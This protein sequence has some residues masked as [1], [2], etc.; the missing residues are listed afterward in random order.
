MMEASHIHNLHVDYTIG[1]ECGL[2]GTH[3]AEAMVMCCRCFMWFHYGC[4]DF[5]DEGG[6]WFCF[7]C[8]AK[9]ARRQDWPSDHSAARR[10]A[11][12]VIKFIRDTGLKFM[13]D[14]HE[15]SRAVVKAVDK[16][17]RR[18][19]IVQDS[20]NIWI[21][22]GRQ[23]TCTDMLLALHIS[24][25][26]S[27]EG[28]LV[29]LFEYPAYATASVTSIADEMRKSF[30]LYMRIKLGRILKRGLHIAKLSC[31]LTNQDLT[32]HSTVSEFRRAEEVKN[33]VNEFIYSQGIRLSG[34]T[35]DSHELWETLKAP[36]TDF[37]NDGDRQVLLPALEV[38]LAGAHSTVD[39]SKAEE[40]LY[41]T[42]VLAISM[43]DTATAEKSLTINTVEYR[44]VRG[45]QVVPID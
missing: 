23:D 39:L 43:K 13:D 18:R 4:C 35:W 25:S 2:C 31:M 15:L 12:P 19:S 11:L 28:K 6:E 14:Q 34:R 45:L 30:T 27:E 17:N 22:G 29:Y 7:I 5:Q 40:A 16:L 38:G 37:I 10:V 24:G 20:K 1:N 33:R 26:L 36:L 8:R 21:S 9:R 41:P 3:T 32:A 42:C 44:A